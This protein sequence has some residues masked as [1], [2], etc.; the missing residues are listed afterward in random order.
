WLRS[1][2]EWTP[3]AS[4]TV[5]DQAYYYKAGRN[6]LDSETYAFDTTTSMIDRDRFAV[7]HQQHIYGNNLDLS[8]DTRLFGLENR[9]AAYFQASSNKIT[10]KQMDDGGFPQDSVAVVGPDP[11]LYGPLDYDIRNSRLDDFAAAFEDRIK[12]TSA[13]ALIGGIRVDD[14]RLARDGINS[15]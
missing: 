5:K 12:L 10:F 8:A 4:I 1:G 11:G 9:F 13:F 2:F 15:D 14:L 6:W 3:L 7:A